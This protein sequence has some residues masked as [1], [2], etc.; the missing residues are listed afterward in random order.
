MITVLRILKF[1]SVQT[2]SIFKYNK[3]KCSEDPFKNINS[4]WTKFYGVFALKGTIN[5]LH[6]ILRHGL[7]D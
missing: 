7:R 6:H 2:N 5:D 4:E 3:K 1:R